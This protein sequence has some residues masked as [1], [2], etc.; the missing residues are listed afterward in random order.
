MNI[1][2]V[3]DEPSIVR[4][5]AFVLEKKGHSLLTACNGEEGLLTAR[6]NAGILD[7]VFLDI[8]MPK[9]NGYEVARRL[10]NEDYKVPIIIFSARGVD[11]DDREKAQIG[12]WQYWSKPFQPIKVAEWLKSFEAIA[13]DREQRLEMVMQEISSNSKNI[14][15]YEQRKRKKSK[16]IKKYGLSEIGEMTSGIVHDMSNNN[17][18]IYETAGELIEELHTEEIDKELF[19]EFIQDIRKRSKLVFQDITKLKNLTERSYT[20]IKPLNINQLIEE[21]LELMQI[22]LI[23]IEKDLS[24]NLPLM[25]G[26]EES[27]TQIFTNLIQNAIQAMSPKGGEIRVKTCTEDNFIRIDFK[28]TGCGIPKKYWSRI[29]E[30]KFSTKKESSGIGLYLVKKAINQHNGKITFVSEVNKGTAFTLYLPI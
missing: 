25:P 8:M 11:P 16:G 18:A 26:N 27:I 5:F 6:Q 7:L 28:D 20:S 24:S 17:M 3:D 19:L 12:A 9:M 13:P 22:R 30:L 14:Q 2:I 21:I 29:F 10:T 15:V 1:L 4:P 23:T